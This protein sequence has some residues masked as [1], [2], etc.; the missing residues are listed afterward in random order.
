MNIIYEAIYDILL[1]IRT[2]TLETIGKPVLRPIRS[3]RLR[4]FRALSG[5]LWKLRVWAGNRGYG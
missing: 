4:S 2:G 5:S 3:N 1:N